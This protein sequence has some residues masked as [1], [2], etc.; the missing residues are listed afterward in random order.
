MRSVTSN[1]YCLT[2][3]R[4]DDWLLDKTINLIIEPLFTAVK[5]LQ[6]LV[7]NRYKPRNLNLIF[8]TTS[9]SSSIT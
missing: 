6:P 5:L 3:L 8:L 4:R 9:N 7:L 1:R 2:T